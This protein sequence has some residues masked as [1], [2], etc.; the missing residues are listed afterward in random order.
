MT[1]HAV[2][3]TE[4]EGAV[5]NF[6]CSKSFDGLKPSVGSNPTV[7]AI[8]CPKI[9]IL[10]FRAVFLCIFCPFFGNCYD[11]FVV[12]NSKKQRLHIIS[13]VYSYDMLQSSLIIC[14]EK[15][16]FGFSSKSS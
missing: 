8:F 4:R 14:V 7:S 13:C 16:L 12:K 1:K 9:R 3:G 15:L 10:G 6:N 11:L 2:F 5:S